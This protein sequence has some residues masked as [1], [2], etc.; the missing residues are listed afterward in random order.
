M[1]QKAFWSSFSGVVAVAVGNPPDICLVRFQTDSMLPPQERRNYK[2][3]FDALFRIAKEEGPSTLWRGS[4]S[5]AGR[6]VSMNVGMLATYDEAK[7][8][9]LKYNKRVKE[10]TG[11]RLL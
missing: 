2:H 9:I 7:E 6:A 5:N 1:L 10:T 4:A 8:Q 3:A 11:D